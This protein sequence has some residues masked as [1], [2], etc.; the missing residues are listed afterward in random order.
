[1]NI[2][3][4]VIICLFPLLT[5]FM[6]SPKTLMKDV[7]SYDGQMVDVMG[8][9]EKIQKVEGPF[10]Y[11]YYYEIRLYLSGEDVFT[12][13]TQTPLIPI[14]LHNG[15]VVK[16]HGKFHKKEIFAKHMY[17]NFIDA[18]KILSLEAA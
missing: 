4:L 12:V 3:T 10:S 14:G 18:E 1:M 16:V 6:L 9:V 13:V 8:V 11:G 7:D 2:K 17:E 15:V 5:A